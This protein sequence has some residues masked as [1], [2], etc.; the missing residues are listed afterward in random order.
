MVSLSQAETQEP[1]FLE[2]IPDHCIL[3][4]VNCFL[5]LKY[6]T[7]G[8]SGQAGRVPSQTRCGPSVWS[9]ML[10]GEPSFQLQT[11]SELRGKAW[12]PL[13]K[14]TSLA[15]AGAWLNPG[16]ARTLL[17]LINNLPGKHLSYRDFQGA[18]VRSAWSSASHKDP[19]ML[20]KPTA[21]ICPHPHLHLSISSP[22]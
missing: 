4:V 21:T 19:K 3:K 16:S 8:W 11:E 13:A 2:T 18:R 12:A 5:R 10:V 9:Q 14:Q 20:S 15:K 17:Q 1:A 22:P 7:R 6:Q